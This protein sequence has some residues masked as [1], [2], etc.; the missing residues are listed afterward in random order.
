MESP[1]ISPAVDFEIV[2]SR[3]EMLGAV[4]DVERS[5]ELAD[6]A[7]FRIELSDSVAVIRLA[8]A[9]S[10]TG[11]DVADWT[12]ILVADRPIAS[13]IAI[14][15]PLVDRL[16]LLASVASATSDGCPDPVE[17]FGWTTLSTCCWGCRN[18]HR[19]ISHQSTKAFLF[20]IV[21]FT[22]IRGG[23]VEQSLSL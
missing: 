21:V 22:R 19:R 18:T 5:E 7:N 6:S 14:A 23:A 9:P 17:A 13:A 3:D 15:V 20:F 10:T 4:S 8:S 11:R 16:A 1:D 12:A 2:A